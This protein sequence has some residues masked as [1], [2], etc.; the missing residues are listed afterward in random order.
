MP[1][2]T[3]SVNLINNKVHNT[4]INYYSPLLVYKT[5]K[6]NVNKDSANYKV[7]N[8]T[9]NNYEKQIEALE[10]ENGNGQDEFTKEKE[11]L[12]NAMSDFFN[13]PSVALKSAML[14]IYKDKPETI[15]TY[16]KTHRHSFVVLINTY[17][18]DNNGDDGLVVY[19]DDYLKFKMP[20]TFF[21]FSTKES[22]IKEIFK[23]KSS[24]EKTN[25]IAIYSN[26]RD[27]LHLKFTAKYLY[28]ACMFHSVNPYGMNLAARPL[29]D[30]EV[31]TKLRD[32]N[33]NFYAYLNETGLER[34]SAFK[35]GVDLAGN[36]IDQLFTYQY[37]KQE[38]I[39][40]LIRV[41]NINNRQNSKLS[42]LQ[43]SGAKDNAYTSAIEC[44]LKRYIER[45][46]IVSY[47]NLNIILSPSPQLK[48]ELTIDITYNYSINSLSFII[49]TKD[50]TDYLNKLEN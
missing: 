23:D 35:E 41:W 30:D 4:T 3:I 36:P 48:L 11:L 38:A 5:L 29:V 50:I 14:F 9:I 1:Q 12:K 39:I 19:K 7:L 27:N 37:I 18:K 45:G 13:S 31:I 15:K 26:K 33:I 40:E 6:I 32:A 34:V 24:L 43:L 42:R 16:L 8:L 17:D 44:L 28:E 47:S 49:T 2:D 25:N 22:E 10:K 21:V 46:L 20:D